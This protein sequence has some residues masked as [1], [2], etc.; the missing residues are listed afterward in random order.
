VFPLLHPY[1]EHFFVFSLV[2]LSEELR[3]HLKVWR[4]KAGKTRTNT[5]VRQG[6]ERAVTDTFSFFKVKYVKCVEGREY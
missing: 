3:T 2:L 6:R 1:W 4:T 5:A